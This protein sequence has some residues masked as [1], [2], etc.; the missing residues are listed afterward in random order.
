MEKRSEGVGIVR[1]GIMDE[2]RTTIQESTAVI[3]TVYRNC[4]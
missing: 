1:P 3:L 2:Y 4:L